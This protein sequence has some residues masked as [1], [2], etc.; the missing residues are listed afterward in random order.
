MVRLFALNAAPIC[1]KWFGCVAASPRGPKADR[2]R[3]RR[4]SGE[5][6]ERLPALR[7]FGGSLDVPRRL[8]PR[9]PAGR[10]QM[11]RREVNPKPAFDFARLA[12]VDV[13]ELDRR[14]GDQ[15]PGCEVATLYPVISQFL[16]RQRC[17]T[18]DGAKRARD[19][20]TFVIGLYNSLTAGKNEGRLASPE[21]FSLA[22]G[23]LLSAVCA[24]AAGRT[25]RSAAK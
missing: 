20:L 16:A 15:A 4:E 9:R 3:H 23:E 2:R 12:N 19:G 25:P 14:C 8:A 11:G 24:F 22:L 18:L 1:P 7:R 10:Q 17:W 13:L 6:I 21:D 5:S